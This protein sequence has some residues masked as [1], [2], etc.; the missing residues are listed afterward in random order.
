MTDST[1]ELTPDQLQE[2]ANT[3]LKLT[4]HLRSGPAPEQALDLAAV[5]LDEDNGL[6]ARLAEALRAT[7]RYLVQQSPVPWEPQVEHTIQWLILAANDIQ[8]WTILHFDV[9]RLRE[10]PFR[11]PSSV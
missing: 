3:L 6:L 8:D 1:T 7:S 9:S 2:A 10:A 4:A 11:S 5:L